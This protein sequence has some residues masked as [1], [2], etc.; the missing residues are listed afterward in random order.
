MVGDVK[1]LFTRGMVTLALTHFLFFFL[2]L[3]YKATR[4]IR[5]WASYPIRVLGLHW[6]AG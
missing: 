4:V 2:C 3:V 5:A 1:C 6:Q